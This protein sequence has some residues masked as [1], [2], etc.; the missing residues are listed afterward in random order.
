[1]FAFKCE[2][3]NGRT[4]RF[5]TIPGTNGQP[6]MPIFQLLIRMLYLRNTVQLVLLSDGHLATMKTDYAGLKYAMPTAMFCFLGDLKYR[7]RLLNNAAVLPG[8][9]HYE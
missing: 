7:K 1:M 5:P 3:L 4:N 9:V 6:G 2:H 8:S